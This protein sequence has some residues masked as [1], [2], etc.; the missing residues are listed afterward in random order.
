[1]LFLHALIVG[2]K[3]TPYEVCFVFLSER[4]LVRRLWWLSVAHTA[5]TG[6]I[7]PLRALVPAQLPL[8]SPEGARRAAPSPLPRSPSHTGGV[9]DRRG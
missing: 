7:L 8:R 5:T 2:P 6:R 1:M 4:A 9:R 3:G